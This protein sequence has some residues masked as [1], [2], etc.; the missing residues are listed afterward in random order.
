MSVSFLLYVQHCCHLV[1]DFGVIVVTDEIVGIDTI[2]QNSDRQ[3][4]VA[5]RSEGDAG[6]IVQ[7]VSQS[8]R[9]RIVGAVH[10][11]L[12]LGISASLSAIDA[13][14]VSDTQLLQF[15]SGQN[16]LVALFA[17]GLQTKQ[18]FD[19]SQ[20]FLKGGTVFLVSNRVLVNKL[21]EGD[22]LALQQSQIVS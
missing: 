7:N 3:A 16:Q 1:E 11:I 18:S 21:L 10:H 6:F 15:I 4:G 14:L 20:S 2:S 22:L 19:V 17:L 13:L 5:V 8:N 12:Q 9:Q